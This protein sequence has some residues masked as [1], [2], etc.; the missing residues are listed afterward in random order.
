[1]NKR[2]IIFVLG[3]PG[4]GKSTQC[5]KIQEK[6]GF[7]KNIAAG[8]LLRQECN[9]ENS[10]YSKII[11]DHIKSGRF[12]P[13][14]IVFTLIDNEINSYEYLENKI[15]LIDG[16]PRNQSNL[17][18]WNEKAGSTTNLIR[19]LHFDCRNQI[20][21][22]RCEKRFSELGRDDDN[23]VALA[24]RIISYKE[25]SQLVVDYYH[26]QDLVSFIDAEA[27]ESRV[28]DQ[29]GFIMEKLAEKNKFY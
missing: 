29:I 28:F 26:N 2:N 3:P 1:M 10:E 9:K 27:D 18:Y 24:N 8:E 16:F 12:I 7:I 13:S 17:E 23:M 19:V 14:E 4:S 11:Q 6:F 15:F 21:A 5:T 20:C 25:T 22:E